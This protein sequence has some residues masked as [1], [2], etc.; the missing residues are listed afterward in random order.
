MPTKKATKKAK[1]AKATPK[2]STKAKKNAPKKEKSVKLPKVV[3]ADK[4]MSITIVRKDDEK[5]L[6]E[7]RNSGKVVG[8]SHFDD[9]TS[10]VENDR[11]VVV[12]RV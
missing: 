11:I 12:T 3:F 9:G 5:T 8:E 2:K 4:R 7:F 10:S 6:T 1:G